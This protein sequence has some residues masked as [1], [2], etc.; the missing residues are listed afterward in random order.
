M[1]LM[2]LP[3]RRHDVD[4]TDAGRRLPL[5]ALGVRGAGALFGSDCVFF[6]F[7]LIYVVDLSVGTP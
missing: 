6:L 5:H 1:Q 4:H 2:C 3:S 7:M